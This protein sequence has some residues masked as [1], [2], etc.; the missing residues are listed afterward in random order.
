MSQHYSAQQFAQR[1]VSPSQFIADK[2]GHLNPGQKKK[3]CDSPWGM[4]V[5]TWDMPCHLPGN[6]VDNPTARSSTGF[7]YLQ[8]QKELALAA[9]D[10]AKTNKTKRS[11]AQAPGDRSN[12]DATIHPP[13][14]LY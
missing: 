10:L 12:P 11:L 5:N 4:H 13:S 3:S 7:K 8:K 1:R 6:N 14:D 9:M 2:R